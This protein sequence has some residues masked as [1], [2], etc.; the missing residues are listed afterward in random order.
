[1]LIDE[2]V[3]QGD[4][5]LLAGRG[6]VEPAAYP[7]EPV[8]HMVSEVGEVVSEFAEVVS[9]V[10]EV[11]AHRVEAGGRGPAEVPDFRANLGYV[12]VG[13]AGQEA[14]GCRVLPG[15]ANVL[16]QL[17]DLGLHSGHA[18]L[19]L[20]GCNHGRKPTGASRARRV[21]RSM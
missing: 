6:G 16:G 4:D 19:E 20:V 1:M 10:G 14:G 18:S 2:R 7:D 13:F 11:L 3:Q 5:L 9:E 21:I 17:L 15:A 8:V 12:T